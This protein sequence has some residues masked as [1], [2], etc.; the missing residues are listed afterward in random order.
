[1]QIIKLG[2]CHAAP[3]YKFHCAVC[4]CI[5]IAAEWELQYSA[6]DAN[7]ELRYKR[8]P[9]CGNKIPAYDAK[10]VNIADLLAE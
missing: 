7:P 10:I 1:M 3:I 9:G 8:C 4:N 5:Y 2:D 6:K